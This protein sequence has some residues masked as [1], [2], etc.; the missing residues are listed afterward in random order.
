MPIPNNYMPGAQIDHYIVIRLLGQGIANR[1]Y[2]AYDLS[3]RQQV[4]LKFPR[5]E[6][7]G[8]AAIFAA[9]R[10]EEE[11]GKRLLHP[12]LQPLLNSDEQRSTD[13]L[14]LEYIPGRPLRTILHEQEGGILSE[15]QLIPLLLPVCDALSYAHCHGVIH[16]DVKPE[17]IL[18]GEDGDVRLLDFGIAL[19]KE[20]HTP[21]RSWRA[22]LPSTDLIGTPA[23]MS[24]ERL[25][26]D[27]GDER[28]DIYALGIV[29]YEALCGRTPFVDPDGFSLTNQQ[30][31]Y[32]PPNILQFNP[33][34]SPALATI[35]MRSIRC[36][37]AKRYASIQD[38]K[39]A[40]LHRDDV[41]VISYIPDPPLLGGRYRQ[42]LAIAALCLV[43]CLAL[44]A[45]GFLAQSVHQTLH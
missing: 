37:L 15:E 20:K 8:G 30:V 34:L 19:L 32:D 6:V 29:L 9:Y 10:R 14:V 4:I 33:A 43:I 25:R 40:L 11:I 12:M 2:L 18:I 27:P 39:E 42:V 1:V 21:L 5:D 28:C 17:N 45:F 24:P 22:W 31:A 38:M 13:Y 23:Y 44:I 41:E 26:G 36:D 7:V 16:R 35:V 3:N